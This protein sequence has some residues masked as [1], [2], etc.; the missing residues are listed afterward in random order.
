MITAFLN[1]TK[2]DS[3]IPTRVFFLPVKRKMVDIFI[4][5]PW[6][7]LIDME[8]K[9]NRV[10]QQCLPY[11]LVFWLNTLRPKQYVNHFTIYENRRIFTQLSPKYVHNGLVNS[12]LALVWIMAR[13]GTGHKP[14]YELVMAQFE[15][16]YMHYLTSMS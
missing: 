11:K 8:W 6:T 1:M 2:Q 3:L 9:S 13:R 5:R 7:I 10:L 16:T 15:D 14:L 12:N 4:E